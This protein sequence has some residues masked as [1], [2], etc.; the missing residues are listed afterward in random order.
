[1]KRST[2]NRYIEI[3]KKAFA[4]VGLHLP[5]FAFW[6]VDD[7]RSKGPEADEIRRGQLGW[8]VTDFGLGKFEE[9]GRTLFTLRNGFRAENGY[10]KTYGEKFILNPPGQ[11]AP[12]HFHRGKMEDIINRGGG[13]VHIKLFASTADGRRSDEPFS[14]QIDGVRH[15]L[16]AG[17]VVR[18]DPGESIY[19]YPG[20]IHQFWG[21]AGIE[22]DGVR[23]TVSGEV[24]SICDDWNDNCFLEPMERFPK[25]E[26]DEPRLHYLCNEYPPAVQS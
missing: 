3:G 18:L 14:V 13:Q 8:D 11:R 15:D 21:E 24:S 12:L 23:Y 9:Y 26:E 19:V 4:A 17:T 7:W 25:I 1:V 6:T 5:P 2:V 10:N 22:I 20:L 16:E